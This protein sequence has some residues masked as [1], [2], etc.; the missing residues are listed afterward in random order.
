M[1]FIKIP[2]FHSFS[3]ANLPDFFGRNT[4]DR[5]LSIVF[6]FAERLIEVEEASL[7]PSDPKFCHRFFF[8][9]FSSACNS[10][11]ILGRQFTISM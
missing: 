10:S 4:S 2:R 8:G 9:L 1:F 5:F 7:I 6:G 11:D 3:Y